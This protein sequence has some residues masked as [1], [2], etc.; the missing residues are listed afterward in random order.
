MAEQP[1]PPT[2]LDVARRADVA[3]SSVSRVLNDHPDVS[4]AMR[5]RVLA[6]VDALGYRPHFIAKS[7]RSGMTY[8]VGFVVRD[9]SNPL[10]AD[11]AK[12]AEDTLRRAGYSMILTNSE[13]DPDLDA[14]YI[15]LLRQRR[16]DAL[17]LSL[18]SESHP[19]TLEALQ[20]FPGPLVL[21]DRE[22]P[23]LEASAVLCDHHSGMHDAVDHLLDLGHRR[24][25]ILAG[26]TAIRATR[27][28][29]RGYREA[30]E[31]RRQWVDEELIRLGAYTRKFAYR[32][33]LSL[34]DLPNPPTALVAGGLQLAAGV[35]LA[36][37]DRGMKAGRDLAF[38]TCD[39][40]DLMRVF[41]PPISAVTRDAG[42]L[43]EQAARLLIDMLVRGAPR[44]VEHLATQYVPRGTSIPF[45]R[46]GRMTRQ[47]S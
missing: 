47:G 43:G 2:I 9:I 10:F 37:H 26:P 15:A 8:S 23:S 17:M 32:E 38:V 39:E 4:P 18:E 42:L 1:L 19:A 16:V 30:Y 20:S 45:S 6:A 25:G 14:E 28:R 35:L 36:A 3:V 7:L 13:G 24:V 31:G 5:R 27:E 33:T 34:L 46:I 44:R 40:I 41:D 29:V 12:G 11:I 22:V 21:L